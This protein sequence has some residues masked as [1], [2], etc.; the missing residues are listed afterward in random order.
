MPRA[1]AKVSVS[2]VTRESLRLADKVA[3]VTGGTSG[4]GAAIVRLFAAEGAQVL[5]CGRRGELGHSLAHELSH[6]GHDVLFVQADITSEDAVTK[7]LDVC[8]SRFGRLHVLVNNAGINR[9]ARLES[10]AATDWRETVA[11][12]LTAHF[13]VLK[14][15]IPLIRESGGG[16]IINIGSTYGIVGSAG[17]PAYAATKAAIINLAKS[18]A[19]DLAPDRIRV[20]ALC[21]GG[22]DT[23][24]AKRWF[25]KQP[26]PAS[27]KAV[28]IV[29][30][31]MQRF[32][33]PDEQ[34]EAA[35]FLASEASSYITGHALVVDGGFLLG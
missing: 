22:T 16:S 23:D 35:L 27:A 1:S 18:L 12:N 26:D 17:A 32:A 31:P 15:A 20:N 21:P 7:L 9:P 25:A 13:F 8:R 28:E 34:A 24:M 30:Y 3:L 4:I 2:T 33:E 5:F 19:V 14:G 11:T 29:H 6:S 10:T